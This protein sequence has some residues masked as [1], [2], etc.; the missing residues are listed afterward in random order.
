MKLDITRDSQDTMMLMHKQAVDIE[1][2]PLKLFHRKVRQL[3]KTKYNFYHVAH[4]Q[5]R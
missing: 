1:P 3:V 2:M 5:K 4:L